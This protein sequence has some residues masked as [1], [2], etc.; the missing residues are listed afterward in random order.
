MV[1]L[2]PSWFSSM[3][4]AGSGPGFHPYPAEENVLPIFSS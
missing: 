2:L 3:A 4:E 1:V